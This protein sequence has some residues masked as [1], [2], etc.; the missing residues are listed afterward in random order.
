MSDRESRV[1]NKEAESEGLRGH[2]DRRKG[3][4]SQMARSRI[5]KNLRS[6][7]Q[8]Q[9]QKQKPKVSRKPKQLKRNEG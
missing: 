5:S 8:K 6:Q 4:L 9:K 1:P 3:G 7:K 2:R